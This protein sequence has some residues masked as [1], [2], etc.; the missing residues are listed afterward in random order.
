[1]KPDYS[2][3]YKITCHSTPL[4]QDCGEMCGGICCLQDTNNSL[5]MY[6]F[7][8]EEVMFNCTEEWLR[9]EKHN[10]REY[11]FPNNW[12]QPVH[13]INCIKPCPREQRPLSC[14]FFPLAPHIM[15][16][17][18]LIITYE[19]LCLPYSCP[20]IGSKE[21][22]RPDFISTVALAW[23]ELLKEER[24]LTLVQED[25]R[26]REKDLLKLPRIL[27]IDPSTKSYY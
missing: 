11:D 14:R 2:Y 15:R 16:D 6:L 9:W 26:E 21:T 22:L 18:T 3:L 27:W 25:S 24:I 1:M 20:L 5:G 17:G 19:T 8:G 12:T 7:P 4:H 10:P 23:Q 13:F